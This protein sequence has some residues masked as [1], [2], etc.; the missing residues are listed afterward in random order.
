MV[1]WAAKIAKFILFVAM[2]FFG[3]ITIPRMLFLLFLP[4]TGG[5]MPVGVVKEVLTGFVFFILAS[6]GFLGIS[7]WLRKQENVFL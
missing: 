5:E 7:S 4:A 2:I 3:A 6:V 1:Y